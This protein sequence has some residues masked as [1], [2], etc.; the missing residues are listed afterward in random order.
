MLL[1]PPSLPPS[2][3][4]PLSLLPPA[5]RIIA[6]SQVPG[7]CIKFA[8]LHRDKLL[9]QKLVHWYL[10]HLARLQELGIISGNCILQ[11][12]AILHNGVAPVASGP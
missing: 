8:Q 4:P 12:A 6:V 2:L 10:I 7:S 5:Y 3:L 9:E 1:P 11:V